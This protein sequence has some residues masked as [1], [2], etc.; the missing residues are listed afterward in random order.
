[1]HYRG[2]RRKREK[3]PKKIVKEIIAE[4]F[5]NSQPSPGSSESSSRINPKRNP[6]R[7]R[8]IKLTKIKDKDQI[9]KTTK[10]KRQHKREIP[11][12]YQLI[13]QQKLYTPEGNG[14]IY[15]K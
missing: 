12:D 13:S 4:N 10:E 14:T 1:M 7:H 3:G 2:P 6:L 9:L 15:L 8:V 11:L 5:I